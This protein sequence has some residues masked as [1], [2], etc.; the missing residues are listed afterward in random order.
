[1][2][3]DKRRP[4]MSGSSMQY[5][6]LDWTLN[7]FCHF[8]LTTANISG[9]SVLKGEIINA[10]FPGFDYQHLTIEGHKQTFKCLSF[11]FWNTDIFRSKGHLFVTNSDVLEIKCNIWKIWVKGMS[12]SYAN[13]LKVSKSEIKEKKRPFSL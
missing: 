4:I 12:R 2:I 9:K 6:L 5:V 1:M 8:T 13:I 10:K 7:F 11:S 3:L